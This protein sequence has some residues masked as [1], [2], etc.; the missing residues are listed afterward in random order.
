MRLDTTFE[1][2]QAPE[3]NGKYEVIPEGWYEAV[4]KNAELK[5]SKSGGQYINIRF[6]VIGEKYAGR[7]VFG[8]ITIRNN[9]PIAEGIGKKQFGQLLLAIGIDECDDTDILLNH[10]LKVYISIQK[11]EQYGDKNEVRKYMALTTAPVLAAIPKVEAAPV[12]SEPLSGSIPPW[13]KKT[14]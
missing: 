4:I 5:N 14:A 6:D 9:N 10:K 13:K 11:S 12:G 3:G 7:V 2:A 8:T 1:A